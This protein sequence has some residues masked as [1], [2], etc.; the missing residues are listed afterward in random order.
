VQENPIVGELETP[1]VAALLRLGSLADNHW[2]AALQEIL[3][4][5]SDV[6]KI[7][8]V[9]CWRFRDEPRSIVCEL[10]YQ[11]QGQRFERG[12]VLR[13]EECPSYFEGIRLCQIMAVDDART[14]ERTGCLRTYLE[15][16]GIGAMLDAPI[17]AGEGPLGI[18]CAE[19]VGGPR[20]WSPQEKEF[21]L[22]VAQILATKLEACARNRA[23]NREQQAILLSDVTAALAE[24]LDAKE[25]ARLA[26]RRALPALGEMAV[27]VTLDGVKTRDVAIAHVNEKGASALEAL[28]AQYPPTLEGPGFLSHA[29]RERQSLLVPYATQEAARNYGASGQWSA[30]ASLGVRTVMAVPLSARGTLSGGMMF[31]RSTG[32]YGPEDLQLAE[33]YTQRI[34]V[35]LENAR[36]Y[37][38]AR[39]A[40]AARDDFLALASHELR[41][42]I[43]SLRLFAQQ[44]AHKAPQMSPVTV[45]GMCERILRQAA[46]LDRMANRLVGACGTGAGSPLLERV[47]TDLNQVVSDV[48]Q[49]FAATAVQAGSDILVTTHGQVVGLWDPIRLE[50]VVGN[51]VDNAIKFGAG[52][53]I[54]IDVGAVDGWATLSVRDQ[55]V[56]LGEEDQKSV[57]DR[58]WRG[59]SAKGFGG[60]GLGLHV[61]REIARALGGTVDVE[62]HVG[63]GSTFTLKL[64][65]RNLES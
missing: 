23:E 56:G 27:L 54:Q 2:D 16:R 1:T 63:Q 34:A 6:L 26:A 40:I 11:R 65:L 28:M 39:E 51:L 36:L 31:A 59:C 13:Q 49:M 44:L 21:S 37:Q 24:T 45:A 62:S 52:K 29:M 8:R 43:T 60:L 33:R 58:Y 38:E 18:L 50:Q 42:P 15:N 25:A 48:A 22:V 9:S 20:T 55:G 32:S 19:H 7:A 30:A 53:P 61:A 3:L 10:G 17:R 14:D 35:L 64:P 5:A 57:F 41:T 12:F 4:F 46:R 47:E